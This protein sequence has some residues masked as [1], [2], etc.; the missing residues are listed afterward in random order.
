MHFRRVA[1]VSNRKVLRRTPE[2]KMAANIQKMTI[3]GLVP[4]RNQIPTVIP[5]FSWVANTLELQST[6]QFITLVPEIKM[7]AR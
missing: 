1:K 3:T 6:L 4:L 5:M 7:A 2:N